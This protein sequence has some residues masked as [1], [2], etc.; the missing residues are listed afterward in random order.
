MGY[1]LVHHHCGWSEV[2]ETSPD[3]VIRMAAKTAIRRQYL[4]APMRKLLFEDRLIGGVLDFGCGR[5]TDASIL[6]LESYDPNFQPVMPT[7]LFDV[8]T[9]IYVLNTLPPDMQV[10]VVE[11]AME[12]LVPGGVLYAAYR[13]DIEPRLQQNWWEATN[14]GT[15]QVPLVAAKVRECNL[16]YEPELSESYRWKMF[17]RVK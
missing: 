1:Q 10:R 8:V 9:M 12:K 17:S 2:V 16:Q 14:L 15:I 13:A 5:G 6:S 3:A 7:G 4:S 11:E